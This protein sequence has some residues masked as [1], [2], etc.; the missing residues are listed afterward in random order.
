MERGASLESSRLEEPVIRPGASRGGEERSDENDMVLDDDRCRRRRS[1]RDEKSI[2]A[3]ALPISL[4]TC[5]A[6]VVDPGATGTFGSSNS[7]A[8]NICCMTD[9]TDQPPSRYTTG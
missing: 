4:V 5:K 9:A 1:L 6:V 2:P 3:S 7:G 8:C